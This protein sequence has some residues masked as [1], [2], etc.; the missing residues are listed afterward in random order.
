MR[1]FH[2]N[3]ANIPEAAE[4]VQKLL[5]PQGK[6]VL[7]KES[8]TLLVDDMVEAVAKVGLLLKALDTKPGRC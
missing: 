8:K 6:M 1:T 4:M 3:Y 7:G 5:S 2:L